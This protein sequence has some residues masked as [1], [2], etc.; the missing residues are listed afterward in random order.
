MT[1]DEL[2]REYDYFKKKVEEMLNTQQLYFKSNKDF[3]L[4]KRSKGLEKEV[5][6]LIHPK[7]KQQ[8]VLSFEFLAQ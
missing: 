5:R 1:Q 4:L 7:P 6:E 2:Q 8:G 3:E